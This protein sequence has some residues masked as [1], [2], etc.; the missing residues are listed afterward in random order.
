MADLSEPDHPSH[1]LSQSSDPEHAEL[2]LP[3]CYRRTSLE[4]AGLGK[5]AETEAKL[6]RAACND[7]LRTLR[8]LLG[9]KALAIK[10]KRANVS[11]ERATTRAEAALKVHKQKIAQA[12]WK[13]NNSREALMRLSSDESDSKVYKVIKAEDL[14]QLKGYLEEDSPGLGQGYRAIPWIWRTSAAANEEEWQLKG[15]VL[16]DAALLVLCLQRGSTS[17]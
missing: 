14:K 13:Y 11:G 12:R 9:A 10:W 15:V 8:N 7:A 5:L 6:R 2:A 17:R 4:S 1:R 16:V 3:S